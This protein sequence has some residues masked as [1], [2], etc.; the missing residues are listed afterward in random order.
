MDEEA[1]ILAHINYK[2]EDPEQL[3]YTP[4][5]DSPQFHY[6]MPVHTLF[7]YFGSQ[8][9]A[10]PQLIYH[11]LPLNFK[12]CFFKYMF[13]LFFE[14]SCEFYKTV[15]P[16]LSYFQLPIPHLTLKFMIS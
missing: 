16:S 6:K 7:I 8:I 1:L 12:H 5:P 11:L 10:Q 13:Y 4:C 14:I 3:D 9:Q 2:H 15:P